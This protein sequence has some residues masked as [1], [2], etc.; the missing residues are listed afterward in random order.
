MGEITRPGGYLKYREGMKG[1][2]EIF[3][4]EVTEKRKGIGTEMV[5]ELMEKYSCIYAFMIER[6]FR[7]HNFY[8]SLGFQRVAKLKDFY[9]A[10]PDGNHR[11][12]VM[13]LW[14]R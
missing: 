13:W 1:S 11:N 3:D 2:C 10:F 4:I 9:P 6:N 12:A 8:R 5:K 7:A 14:T